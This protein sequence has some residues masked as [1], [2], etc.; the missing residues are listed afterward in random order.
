MRK[1]HG[2]Y[3]QLEP[4]QY[5]DQ[6]DGEPTWT[7]NLDEPQHIAVLAI[8]Q[9]S[10]DK[11]LLLDTRDGKTAVVC[12]RDR[13][14]SVSTSVFDNLAEYLDDVISEF[15]ALTKIPASPTEIINPHAT[16]FDEEA[17]TLMREAYR[18]HAWSSMK[19]DKEGCL[20]EFDGIEKAY[21]ER[22]ETKKAAW[23]EAE[24][25]RN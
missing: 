9:R 7:P 10:V 16:Y 4:P 3:G 1:L 2:Q 22:W 19:Y 5:F 20:A 24:R 12:P 23:A 6:M 18:K 17:I 25:R 13:Y 8:T 14:E 21:T 15:C 11:Y